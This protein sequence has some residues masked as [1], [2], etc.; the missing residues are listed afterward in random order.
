MSSG[1]FHA[2]PRLSAATAYISPESRDR[3]ER[4]GLL[5]QPKSPYNI[6]RYTK[7]RNIQQ[8]GTSVVANAWIQHGVDD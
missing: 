6:S 2:Y 5:A 4:D 3:Q 8:V 1:T 7:Q